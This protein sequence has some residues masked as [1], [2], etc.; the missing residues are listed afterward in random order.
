MKI[1]TNEKFDKCRRILSIMAG[2]LYIWIV[3]G[4]LINIFLIPHALENEEYYQPEHPLRIIFIDIPSGMLLSVCMAGVRLRA[5]I[6]QHNIH[7]FYEFL[8]IS[9]LCTPFLFIIVCGAKYWQKKNK[10]IFW[11]TISFITLF[12]IERSING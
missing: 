3:V 10:Y 5:F 7:Y 2:V 1:F 8:I 11:V 12:I 9:L 4:N 6:L